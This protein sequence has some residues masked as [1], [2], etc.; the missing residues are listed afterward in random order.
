M[1]QTLRLGRIAGIPIGL[2]WS[3]LV[4]VALI[5]FTLADG[6]LPTATPGLSSVTYWSVAAPT[7]VLF[8]ASL[9]AHELA[10]SIVAKH[11]H[12]RVSGITLWMLGGVSELQDEAPD[13]GSE[14]AIAIVGPLTSLAA[15]VLFGLAAF[16]SGTLGAPDI[17]TEVLIWLAVT[18]AILAVFNL[19][20]GA[21]LD[22]GR[23][24]R[25]YVWKRHGDRVRAD[26]A[27]ARAGRA[28]GAVLIA[29]GA[30]EMLA[31]GTGSGLW[32]IILGWFLFAAAGAEVRSRI[33][34][35]AVLGLRA[36][37]VM[38]A[39]PEYGAAWATV[40]DFIT[41]VAAHSRQPA[42]PVADFDGRPVGVL[43][44]ALLA[45]VPVAVRAETRLDAA[46]VPVPDEYV[47]SADVPAEEL[48]ERVPLAGGLVA[49]VVDG[50]RIIGM[51]TTDDLSHAVQ[52]SRLLHDH[53]MPATPTTPPRP[54]APVPP[55]PP[56]APPE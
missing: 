40:A 24:L 25:A 18:N 10:H 29:A 42:F 16:A 50:G 33:A 53:R 27:A 6:V 56:A 30:M 39:R 8:F 52:R 45:R 1:K 55:T 48:F 15:G 13:A 49:V 44:S 26:Q 17:I 43:S 20:P 14:L 51:V 21:P 12:L 5:T 37:D 36:S 35:E 3:V 2:H 11:R 28:I 38:T 41:Q 4:I 46:A 32:L 22:G 9:L 54:P 7:S 23:V 19:L 47:I 31:W 34:H